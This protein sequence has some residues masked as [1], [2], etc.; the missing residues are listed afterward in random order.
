MR[1]AEEEAYTE[2][3]REE[4]EEKKDKRERERENNQTYKCRHKNWQIHY[5][6]L[7]KVEVKKTSC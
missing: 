1:L 4:K 6:E 5:Y 3:H 7:L 2:K